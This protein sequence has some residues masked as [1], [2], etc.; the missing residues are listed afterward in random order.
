[1]RR[2]GL[3]RPIGTQRCPLVVL[4]VIAL[5]LLPAQGVAA[6]DG[7]GAQNPR[8]RSPWTKPRRFRDREDEGS[9]PSP[10][11]ISVFEIGDFG[12][13]PWRLDTAGSQFP[14]EQ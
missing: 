12:G 9:N 4:C 13:C 6:A 1:M 3:F 11:T 14:G 8:H 10:P 2:A 5:M 7:T